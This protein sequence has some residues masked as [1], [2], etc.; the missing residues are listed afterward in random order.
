VKQSGDVFV[1]FFARKSAVNWTC[2]RKF[3]ASIVIVMMLA[4]EALPSLT[5][6]S[7]S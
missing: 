4:T 2:C 5:V 7:T 3:S 6:A 1:R